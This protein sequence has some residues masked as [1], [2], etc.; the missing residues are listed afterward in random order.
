MTSSTCDLTFPT[1]SV[2]ISPQ[3]SAISPGMEEVA[4]IV[5]DSTGSNRQKLLLNSF[6]IVE[7][8]STVVINLREKLFTS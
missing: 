6:K 7:K 2:R 5:G 3:G 8:R 4:D 1:C